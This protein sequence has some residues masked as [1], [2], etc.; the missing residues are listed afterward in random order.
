MNTLNIDL[1]GRVVIIEK[2]TVAEEYSHDTR[3]YVAGGFGAMGFTMGEKMHGVW[4][5]DGD[6]ESYALGTGVDEALTRE[7]WASGKEPADRA[8]AQQMLAVRGKVE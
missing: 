2:E 7:Y 4:L 3:F 6:A 8:M 1:T 5:V